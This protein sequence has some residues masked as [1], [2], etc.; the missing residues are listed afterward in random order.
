MLETKH[1]SL[2]YTLSETWHTQTR[3]NRTYITYLF[4]T[5][6]EMIYLQ[7]VYFLLLFATW[8][9]QTRTGSQTHRDTHMI[10]MY[11]PPQLWQNDT[12]RHT[13]D[14]HVSSSSALTDRHTE[15]HTWYARILLLSSDIQT[16]GD[17]HRDI[18]HRHTDTH[19]EALS[20]SQ[21]IEHIHDM[22]VSSSSYSYCLSP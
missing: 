17:T 20:V 22:H 16:H 12:K 10:C 13:H 19:T 9:T 14:M 18:T 6:F 11:P 1:I 4:D 21:S 7:N 15:T 8:H 2:I 3:V 5:F